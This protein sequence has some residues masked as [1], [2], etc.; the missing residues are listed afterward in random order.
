MQ[1]DFKTYSIPTIIGQVADS[2]LNQID[3]YVAEDDI[4]FGSVVKRG[5]KKDKQALPND[6]IKEFL[7]IAVRN[8]LS[9]EGLYRAKDMVSVMTRG[10]VAVLTAEAVVAGDKAYFHADGTINKTQKD[11]IAIGSF[12]STQESGNQLVILEIK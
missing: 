7:G 5:T 8:D 2:S 1:K 4:K 11:G 9:R 6:G 12:A 3:S 10:R